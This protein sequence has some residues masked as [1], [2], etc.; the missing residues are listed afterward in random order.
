[1]SKAVESRV[2]DGKTFIIT[3]LGVEDALKVLIW[4]TRSIGGTLTKSL[5]ELSSFKD[6]KGEDDVDLSKLSGVLDGCF[7]RIDEKET[8]GK[9]EILLSAVSYE[10]QSLHFSHPVLHGEPLLALKLAKESMGVNFKS[11]LG[12]ISDVVGKIKQSVE[13]IHAEAK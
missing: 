2:I 10:T 5:G 8:I 4:L 9:I 13:I 7:E 11:F 3:K 1:M 12:G 6:L